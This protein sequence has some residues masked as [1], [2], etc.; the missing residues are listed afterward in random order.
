M[1]V[2]PRDEARTYNNGRDDHP[3]NCKSTQKLKPTVKLKAKG[4]PQKLSGKKRHAAPMAENI[5]GAMK[6]SLVTWR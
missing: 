5:L 1:K 6:H 3:I 4:F 2:L